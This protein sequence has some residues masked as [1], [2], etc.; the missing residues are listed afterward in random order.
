M[1]LFIHVN[2]A[3]FEVYM[4]DINISILD[5]FPFLIFENSFMNVYECLS[6]IAA[7]EA[8]TTLLID[9]TPK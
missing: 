6:H 2:V 9:S 1:A 7:P 3:C 4:S 5:F 8:V